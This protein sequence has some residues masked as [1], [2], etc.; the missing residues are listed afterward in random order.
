MLKNTNR[1][2]TQTKRAMEYD[3][4]KFV[5]YYDYRFFNITLTLLPHNIYKCLDGYVLR[6]CFLCV[7][8]CT[9]IVAQVL[10]KDFPRKWR[11][12]K[13]ISISNGKYRRT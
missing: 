12:T 1:K 7:C 8:V 11:K 10:G 2:Q 5:I 4:G 13:F 6:V 3:N 9:C